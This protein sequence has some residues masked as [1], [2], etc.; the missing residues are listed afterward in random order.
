MGLTFYQIIETP[1]QLY[2]IMEYMSGGELF[3][4]IVEHS[5]VKEIEACKFFQ[6]II[7]GI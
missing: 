6:Q 4:Y 1:K 2:L 5:R 7:A 3:D